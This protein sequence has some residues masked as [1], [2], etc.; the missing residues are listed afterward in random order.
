LLLGTEPATSAALI[1]LFLDD[2]GAAANLASF[3]ATSLGTIGP[4]VDGVRTW[5]NYGEEMPADVLTDNGP[6]PANLADASA[7]EDRGR[8]GVE[9]EATDLEGHMMPSF[10]EGETNF[11]DWYYP[12]PGLGVVSGLGLDTASTSSP[13]RTTRPTT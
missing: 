6:M 11:S 2:D 1:G 7:E 8:W 13:R 4:T 5:L 9:V 12:S 3:V 10:Y